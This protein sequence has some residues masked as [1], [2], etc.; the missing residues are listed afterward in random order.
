MQA[1]LVS[2]F[3]KG[4]NTVVTTYRLITIKGISKNSETI[5]HH[6]LSFSF[7]FKLHKSQYGCIKLKSTKTIL[8]I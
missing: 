3:K 4:N 2:V 8:L 6:Q 5:T 7:K 1:A